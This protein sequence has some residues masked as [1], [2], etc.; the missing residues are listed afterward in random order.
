MQPQIADSTPNH[1]SATD[2]DTLD[3]APNLH[4]A[5]DSVFLHSTPNPYAAAENMVLIVPQTRPLPQAV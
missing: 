1:P 4:P 5:V 3:S 2:Y